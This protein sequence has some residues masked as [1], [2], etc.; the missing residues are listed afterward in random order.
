MG[1]G[2]TTVTLLA[3][4]FMKEAKQFIEEGLHSQVIIQGYKEALRLSLE[5]LKAF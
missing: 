4:E 5:K 3:G 2:T 1:D